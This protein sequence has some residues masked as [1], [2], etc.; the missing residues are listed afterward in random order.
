MGTPAIS[1]AS[2]CIGIGYKALNKNTGADNVAIGFDACYFNVTGASN[3]IIG[4]GAGYGVTANSTQTTCLWAT[5]A[6]TR[7]TTVEATAS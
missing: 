5:R 2:N 6:G 4:S 3:V 7:T 1:T